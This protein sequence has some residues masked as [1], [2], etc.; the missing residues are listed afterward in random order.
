MP[1][2]TE[3][4]GGESGFADPFRG[5]MPKIHG[6]VSLLICPGIMLQITCVL[7]IIIFYLLQALYLPG[8][9]AATFFLWKIAIVDVSIKVVVYCEFEQLDLLLPIWK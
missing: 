2:P 7:L 3:G 6:C 8:L 1:P 4:R 9:E 5:E